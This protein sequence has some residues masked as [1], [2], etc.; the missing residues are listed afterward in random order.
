MVIEESDECLLRRW[1]M[2]DS[3]AFEM[4]YHRHNTK[5]LGY[6]RKKGIHKDEL[7]EIVQEVFFKLHIYISHYEPEKKALPWFFTIVHNACMDRLKLGGKAKKLW[8]T[9]S[10]DSIGFE[11]RAQGLNV[12]ETDND[13]NFDLDLA[14]GM[15]NCEQQK[16]VNMRTQ[17][18]MSFED[19]AVAT[20]KSAVSLRKVYSRA[21]HLMRHW[22][23]KEKKQ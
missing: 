13:S 9:V 1:L 20:G 11:P 10:L 7:T 4:F 6:A 18:E 3:K 2:G 5:V 12:F 23:D 17:E 8:Q 14:F 19:I 22:F 16:V 21:L 15:L